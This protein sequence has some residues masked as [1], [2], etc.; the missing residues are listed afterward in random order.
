MRRVVSKNKEWKF[1]NGSYINVISSTSTS[2]PAKCD[3][4]SY[5]E[6]TFDENGEQMDEAV[7]LLKGFQEDP[8]ADGKKNDVTE[9]GDEDPATG[10]TPI[11]GEVVK[12]FGATKLRHCMR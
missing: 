7:G 8:W 1:I 4:V 10:F 12:N 11:G 6:V 5:K 2:F 3:G 9:F